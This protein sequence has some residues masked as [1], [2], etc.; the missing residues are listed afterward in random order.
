MRNKWPKPN[1]WTEFF[2]GWFVR[3]SLI[4][5]IGGSIWG[6]KIAADA[7]YPETEMS[8]ITEHIERYGGHYGQLIRTEIAFSKT[9]GRYV[10]KY[11]E[12]GYEIDELER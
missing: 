9:R 4:A 11:Y 12:I 10:I 1:S 3:L 5:V 8:R 6:L 7:V 2:F